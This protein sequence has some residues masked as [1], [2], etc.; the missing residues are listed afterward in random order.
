MRSSYIPEAGDIVWL[1]FDPQAGHEQK[2]H[3]P[4]LVLTPASYN[5]KTGLMICCPMTTQTK[6]YPFE[7]QITGKSPGVALADQ[8]KSMDWKER[9]AR[10]KGQATPQELDEARAKACVL[11]GRK[12]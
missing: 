1:Q 8:V 4:A 12:M 3:R 10:F 6:G 2:G 5:G 9:Q 7:V 11:I